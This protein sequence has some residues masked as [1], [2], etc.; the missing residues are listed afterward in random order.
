MADPHRL[1][2]DERGATA[3]IVVLSLL[4]L[5][6]LVVLTV[7]VGQLL[8]QRRGMVNASDAAALAAAQTC[9][10]LDDS[11]VPEAVADAFA[12][13][14]V[15]SAITA[16]PNITEMVGC[17][18]PA[19]GH[20][21]VEY[22]M[23]QNLFF[24]GVL[25]I[26]GPASVRTA[27]TAGWGPSGGANPLPIVVYVGNDQGNCDIE[28]GTPA[29]VDCYLWYDNDLFENSAF[30]F[31]N[32]CTATDPCSHGWDVAA[33]ANCPN[34]GSSLRDDWIAG[35]WT[36]GPNELNYPDPTYVCVVTG[37]SSSNWVEL[38]RRVGDD[39]I[40]PVDDCPTNVDNNGNIVGCDAFPNKYNIVGFI[41]LHLDAVLDS[42][43]EWGGVAQTHCSPNNVNVTP[44]L[45]VPL[46]SFMGG[47]CPN[48]S[49]PSGVLDFRIDDQTS[50]PNWMYDDLNK[51]F[52]WTGPADRV[53]V[54]F[55]WWLDG[56]CGQPPPNSSAVC[57]KVHTVEVRF[58]G[59]SPGGGADFGLRSIRLCD[60][61]FGSCP[62][63]D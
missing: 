40:F 16:V 8:F 52:T 26:S 7:D 62:E 13:N 19:Y 51:Q 35:N 11:D 44:G 53:N 61:Q 9:A 20:V 58:G 1:H 49:T 42:A 60:M 3:V 17:D 50:S 32:L 21:S 22:A 59:T 2:D 37:L 33:N 23:N 55:D 12:V 57:I 27:A 25:G 24:A 34:V 41:T 31:L 5:F 30:G 46:S 10:G 47:S 48:G 29:G 4:A 45:V 14:N 6:G 38:D 43:A 28:E 18:G 15:G 63:Q 54:D 56:E 39:L 36:G